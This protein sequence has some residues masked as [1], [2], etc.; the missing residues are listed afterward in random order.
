MTIP[1]KV[2]SYMAVGKPI[3]GAVNGSCANFIIN[4]EVGY[5]CPSNDEHAFTNI[6]K[7]LNIKKLQNIGKHAKEVYFKKYKKTIYINKLINTLE[8]FANR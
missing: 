1:G 7:G 5:A 2:Q 6:V 8:E 4:N 3:I